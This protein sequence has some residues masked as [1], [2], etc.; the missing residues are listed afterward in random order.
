MLQKKEKI[1]Y[2]SFY[3][4]F[5][6]G[7]MKLK[8]IVFCAACFVLSGS[9]SA[10]EPKTKEIPD[11]IPIDKMKEGLEKGKGKLKEVKD[12]FGDLFNK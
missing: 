8:F 2:N 7:F 9:I 6:G 5:H 10:K 11:E 3:T 4:I 12:K 1:T